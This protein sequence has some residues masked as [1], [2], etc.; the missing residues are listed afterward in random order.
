MK[1]LWN[2]ILVYEIVYMVEKVDR[3]IAF[4][5]SVIILELGV[6]Q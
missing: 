3:E 5:L 4:L 6:T 2:T 1:E